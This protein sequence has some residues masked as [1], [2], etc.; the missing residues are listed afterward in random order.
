MYQILKKKPD[1]K[2][3]QF[4]DLKSTYVFMYYTQV[5]KRV[6]TLDPIGIFWNFLGLNNLIF[7][8][9]KFSCNKKSENVKRNSITKNRQTVVLCKEILQKVQYSDRMFYYVL[10]L[11]KYTISHLLLSRQLCYLLNFHLFESTKSR[12]IYSNLL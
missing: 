11:S 12:L 8:D 3:C 2:L 6:L 9:G 7:G 4:Y 1:Q 10:Q 5:P